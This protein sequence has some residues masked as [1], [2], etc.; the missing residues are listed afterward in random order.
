MKYAIDGDTKI[1]RSERYDVVIVGAGLAGLYT[2]L[3]IDDRLSCCILAKESIDSSSSWFAQGGI[4]AAVAQD[5]APIFHLEDTLIAGAGLC[6]R[7]SVEVLVG[8]GP[9]DIARLV[10]LNVPF[11]L[12]EAGDLQITREGGHHKNRVL[13]AGGDATGR[14][15]VKALAH[16]VAQRKN[17]VFFE[18]SCVF[19]VVLDS[20][21]S[22]AG[23]VVRHDDGSFILIETG[24]VVLATGG[25]GQVYRSS[26]N[27]SVAT[28]DGLAAA[29]RVGAKVKNLEFIQFHPTGL[30]CATPEEREFLISEA[31]RGEG[32]LLKN[33]DGVRFMTGQHELGEL[34]PRDIVARGIFREMQRSGED[35]VYVDI[36]AESEEQLSRRFPTIFNECLSRG[37]N[38]SEDWIPVCPVQHYLMGGIETDLYA[39][40]NIQGLYACGEVACTG[41][42]GANRLASNSMLE[43]LVYGRRAA[44]DINAMSGVRPASAPDI[45]SLP[46]RPKSELNCAAIRDRIRS[47]MSEYGYVIR[48]KSGLTYAL[49][50]VTA[51][52]AQLEAVY[53]DHTD[54]LEA[55]NIAT[56]AREVLAAA[57]AR[58][59]SI[60]SHYIE[61]ETEE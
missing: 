35:H 58:P 14:E 30:W 6:D 15:T 40:T 41:V 22:A 16:I 10:S 29:V 37:I 45:A 56:V 49:G 57:L 27:P 1:S 3:N 52:L 38:I 13:H 17:I 46:K 2:A 11:D 26:T 32:G 42:H 25:I 23:I 5:D 47:L 50:E 7:K 59:E 9:R 28:G 20:N 31:V 43:C 34:A 4:A 48:K 24:R 12:D 21:G 39:R 36:T 18:H 33:K 8:E 60:G 55:L 54:Y 61:P 44:E 19:D 51:M 53:S